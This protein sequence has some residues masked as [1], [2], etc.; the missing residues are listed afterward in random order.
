MIETL[1]SMRAA[2][3]SWL[4]ISDRIG[5]A[6]D[7]CWRKARELEVPTERRSPRNRP[8]HVVREA[9]R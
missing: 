8:V 2:G 1:R 9:T 4:A 7:T 6:Y 3:K 5:V